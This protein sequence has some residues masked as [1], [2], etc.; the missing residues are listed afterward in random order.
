MNPHA[1][2]NEI[3]YSQYGRAPMLTSTNYHEWNND[4]YY[5]LLAARAWNIVAGEEEPPQ[6]PAA[7][8]NAQARKSYEK[9]KES[10]I[11]RRDTAAATIYQSCSLPIR[12]YLSNRPSPTEMWQI[13][14]KAF[15]R[16]GPTLLRRRLNSVKF[17]GEGSVQQYIS[18]VLGYRDHLISTPQAL[19]EED[20]IRHLLTNLPDSWMFIQAVISSQPDE[21]RTLDYVI[22][23]LN[24][25]ETDMLVKLERID[26][27]PPTNALLATANTQ[28]H[29]VNSAASAAHTTAARGHGQGRSRPRER[30]NRGGG[31]NGRG[32]HNRHNG[33]NGNEKRIS[34]GIQTFRGKC[35]WCSR[36]G[37]KEG[38]CRSKKAYMEVKEE[39]ESKRNVEADFA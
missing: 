34:K 38:E 29:E 4:I 36:L 35:Y 12:V 13:L 37:H 17:D 31:S 33:Q 6:A 5:V 2:T 16:N 19:T 11:S 15:N 28:G 9:A 1:E 23:A 14:D 26:E 8:A 30:G 27:K 32:G 18:K 10:Y 21:V 22:N 3:Y 25:Y 20:V 39:R 24:N 7:N